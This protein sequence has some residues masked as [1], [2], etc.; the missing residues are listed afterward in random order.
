[1]YGC[2][3][4]W[5]VWVYGIHVYGFMYGWV[6]GC[7]YGCMGVYGCGWE[8]EFFFKIKPNQHTVKP[9]FY[10]QQQDES[11]TSVLAWTGHSGL[12]SSAYPSILKDI[13]T[14]KQ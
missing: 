6:Y 9:F 10:Q 7:V 8:S 5:V 4:V 11:S 13:I 14:K 2:M 1:M 3:D 12:K